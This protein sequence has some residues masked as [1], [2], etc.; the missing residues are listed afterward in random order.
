M[1]RLVLVCLL[2]LLAFPAAA[3]AHPLGNFTVNR[4]SGIEL[5]GDRI[6]VHHVLD[7]AEIPTLQE[8]SRVRA[9]GFARSRADSTCASTAAASPSG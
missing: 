4:Y 2:L 7:L 9:P 8:G 1:K 3:G 5:S 6:Y